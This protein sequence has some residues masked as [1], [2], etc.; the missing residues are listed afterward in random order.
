MRTLSTAR[1][2]RCATLKGRWKRGRYWRQCK[3][4]E[5]VEISEGRWTH[6]ERQW[7]ALKLRRSMQG[8][9]FVNASVR[10][11]GLTLGTGTSTDRAALS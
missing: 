10:P 6:K 3:A 11:P 9:S 7:E 2:A 8:R 4:L 5:A 1:P